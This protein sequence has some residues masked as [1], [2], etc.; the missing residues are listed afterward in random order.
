MNN[1][2]LEEAPIPI[3]QANN[4]YFKVVGRD[5]KETIFLFFDGRE[6]SIRGAWGSAWQ[7]IHEMTTRE[8]EIHKPRVIVFR[9]PSIG[10]AWSKIE[11]VGENF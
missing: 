4:N 5:L 3:R 8:R 1:P 10:G 2:M 7:R 11:V 6:E 9:R